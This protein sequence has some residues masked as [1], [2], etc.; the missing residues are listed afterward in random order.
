MELNSVLNE[1]LMA[2]FNEATTKKH[3]Y[4]T[5]EHILYASLFFD[6]GKVLI[7]ALGGNV[8]NLK[9]TIEDFFDKKMEKI[10]GD[11][12]KQSVGFQNVIDRKSVV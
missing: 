10:E 4:L 7:E 3:E 11:E 5:P 8:N 9:T 6:E 1:V 2:A 12:P